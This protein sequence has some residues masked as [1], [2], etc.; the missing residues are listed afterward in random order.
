[1][2]TRRARLGELVRAAGE[3]GLSITDLADHIDAFKRNGGSGIENYLNAAHAEFT[4]V[5]DPC[6]TRLEGVKEQVEAALA[7]VNEALGQ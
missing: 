7:A 1:M 4:A 6:V 3:K 2:T 5:D